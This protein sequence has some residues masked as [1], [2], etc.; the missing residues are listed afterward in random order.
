MIL[1]K[2]LIKIQY[3]VS[4]GIYPRTIEHQVQFFA[5]NQITCCTDIIE[6]KVLPLLRTFPV[7]EYST[8]YRY[9]YQYRPP[10]LMRVLVVSRK[11]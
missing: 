5:S 10:V 2:I 7:S 1:D 8:W 9:R 3:V 11:K 4:T 6:V